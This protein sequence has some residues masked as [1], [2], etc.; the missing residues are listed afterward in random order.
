MVDPM[1][2]LQVGLLVVFTRTDT[3]PSCSALV[4]EFNA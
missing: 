4:R 3:M 2:I 1:N